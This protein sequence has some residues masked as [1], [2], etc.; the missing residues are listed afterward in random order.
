MFRSWKMATIAL[1][2]SSAL[3]GCGGGG[4]GSSASPAQF[5]SVTVTPVLGKFSS[6]TV[7]AY[8]TDGT[9]LASAS[10]DPASGSA[11]L[12]LPAS[13]HSPYVISVS[14]GSYFDEGT[15]TV[16]AQVAALVAVVAAAAPGSVGVNPLTNAAAALLGVKPAQPVQ[17]A[18]GNVQQANLT[19]ATLLG[20]PGVDPTLVIPTPIASASSQITG[21]SDADKLAAIVAG[22]AVLAHNPSDGYGS[23]D[24]VNAAL[25]TQ[26][27]AAQGNPVNAK[28]NQT[29]VDA[30]NAAETSAVSSYVSP[31]ISLPVAP[32]EP[33]LTSTQQSAI[34][35]GSPPPTNVV[36]AENFIASVRNGLSPYVNSAGTG[37]LNQQVDTIKSDLLSYQ[38][39]ALSG[40]KEALRIASYVHQVIANPS[41]LP[42]G[43]TGSIPG[44]NSSIVCMADPGS[45]WSPYGST[46]KLTAV[47]SSVNGS[48]QITAADW[49][50]TNLSNG[51]TYQG[52]V[53]VN[54]PGTADNLTLSGAL[55]PMTPNGIKTAVG[56]VQG[57]TCTTST[58]TAA[59]N[60]GQPFNVVFQPASPT[61]GVDTTTVSGSLKDLVP[62]AYFGITSCFGHSPD[63]SIEL[64]NA[65]APATVVTSNTGNKS[66]DSMDLVGQFLT[67]HYTFQG[68]LN[69]PSIQTYQPAGSSYSRIT[70]GK[71]DFT[72]AVIGQGVSYVDA[73][74][75]LQSTLPPIGNF[76]VLQG[77]L[78]STLD[79]SA[80]D[81]TQIESATNFRSFTLN[82][83]GTVKN[84]ATDPGLEL[85]LTL[86]RTWPTGSTGYSDTFSASYFDHNQNL[87]VSIG[88]SATEPS[89]LDTLTLSS[90]S[91]VVLTWS[92]STQ[93]GTL[94]SAG[95]SVGT[96]SGSRLSFSDGT[97]ESLF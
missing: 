51:A 22:L 44:S 71:L 54:D 53:T 82:F 16:Q 73:S 57:G 7:T 96:I 69:V 94:T 23:I 87:S 59:P 39:P 8:A 34:S 60:Y 5:A 30:Y 37:F 13:Y 3:A 32:A 20:L 33:E 48:S 40:I 79:A 72:G 18:A 38:T 97:Y 1:A 15:G 4:G 6:G 35:S 56:E 86:G 19:V 64:G 10:I 14:G 93:S 36:A 61:S 29:L 25:A 28:L 62:D 68:D 70:G 47:Q 65:T 31:S 88:S 26:L 84:A 63:L 66:Q 80:Y 52:V 92:R 75:N 78:S 50:V 12:Q 74:G 83:D 43:C 85:Q 41:Q 58:A 95:Q 91:G 24:A 27:A 90:G 17:V 11:Q 76:D 49:V 42:G 55:D 46:V 89:V 67:P 9:Q 2:I 77:T 21:V 81:P 45:S